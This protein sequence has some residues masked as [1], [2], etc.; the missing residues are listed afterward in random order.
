[1]ISEFTNKFIT[2]KQQVLFSKAAAPPP[3]LLFIL[4]LQTPLIQSTTHNMNSILIM[5]C[6]ISLLLV[7]P[8]FL[9]PELVRKQRQTNSKHF[10]D[11]MA[12]NKL[13][14]RRC[15]EHKL[16]DSELM[17]V[18]VTMLNIGILISLCAMV[19]ELLLRTP[20][21][22]RADQVEA[23]P[24]TYEEATRQYPAFL[25]HPL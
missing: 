7:L 9:S 25:H 11:A 24:P 16:R 5:V 21:S 20:H 19:N 23:Q 2:K 14:Q 12:R 10:F 17:L 15:R 4:S 8:A 1:M 3:L 22:R 18:M 6:G 13:K